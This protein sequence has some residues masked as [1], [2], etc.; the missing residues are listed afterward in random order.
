MKFSVYGP[1]DL[2]SQKGIINTSKNAKG[3]FWA[4][5]EKKTVVSPRLAVVISMSFKQDEGHCLGTSA[6]P[7]RG[8]SSSKL[9]GHI[10]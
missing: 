8:P 6:A 5:V 9:S 10:T 3:V 7:Q 2:P 1:Y 4:A